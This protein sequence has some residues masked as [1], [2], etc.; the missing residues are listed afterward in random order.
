MPSNSKILI[1]RRLSGNAGAPSSLS[2]GELAFNEIDSTLYYGAGD[3]GD[4]NAINVI[5]IAG[6][7]TSILKNSS[8]ET[9]SSPTTASNDYLVVEI[10][11]TI[12]AIRL[13]D[14]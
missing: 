3:D 2:N 5:P 9:I 1:R 4:G 14:F 11:G 13:F 8:I 12:R 6:D 7:F 10:N